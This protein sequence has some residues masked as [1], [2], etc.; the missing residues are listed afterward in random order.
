[1]Y[2]RQG[3]ILS[4]LCR[5]RHVTESA[6]A[7]AFGVSERTI[8]KDIIALSCI[9]PIKTIRGRHGGGIWLEDWFNPD[10]NT[11]AAKQEELLKQILPT[12]VG[13]DAVVMNSIL[14]Q[15]APANRYR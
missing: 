7:A 2:E 11:L 5:N 12:L 6:L 14:T 8:R 9:I 4:L 1:M 10:S 15:F 3:A 13:E